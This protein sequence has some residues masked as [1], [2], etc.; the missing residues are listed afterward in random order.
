[1]QPVELSPNRHQNLT[2]AFGLICLVAILSLRVPTELRTYTDGLRAVSG[3]LRAQ[4]VYTDIATDILGFRAV[5]KDADPYLPLSV[6]FAQHD[7]SWDLTTASTHPPSAYL[8]TAPI[9][10]L[11]L[12]AAVAAWGWLMLAVLCFSY[13]LLGAAPKAAIGLGCLSLL[14]PPV[15]MSLQQLTIVWLLGVVAAI[16]VGR[17]YGGAA[18]ALA[19]MTKLVPALLILPFVVRRQWH[20]VIAFAA[21]WLIAVSVLM[22]LSPSVIGRYV[23][24]NRTNLATVAARPDNASPVVT[25]RRA[26]GIAAGAAVVGLAVVII[27]VALKSDLSEML[28]LVNYAIVVLLPIAWVY[29]SC[30]L[31][32]MFIWFLK[33]GPSWRASLTLVSIYI[34]LV[35]SSFGSAATVQ[36]ALAIVLPGVGFLIDQGR[37]TLKKVTVAC[38]A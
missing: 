23:R 28:L 22:F 1:M 9:A 29:S 31:I 16:R 2:L 36:I 30:V 27:A 19:A 4:F 32:P 6:Y 14:W 26:G 5:V 24:V 34:L 8:L 3:S 18:L 21:A 10:F 38:N 7:I 12:S 37:L 15:M 17:G 13:Y 25:A 33:C 35:G 11:P 20:V